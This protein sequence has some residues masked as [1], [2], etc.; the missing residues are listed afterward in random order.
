[1][2]HKPSPYRTFSS[3]LLSALF[4]TSL[5]AAGAVI[6]TFYAQNKAQDTQAKVSAKGEQTYTITTA[7]AESEPVATPDPLPAPPPVV[8]KAPVKKAQAQ[9]PAK[10]IVAIDMSGEATQE[11]EAVADAASATPV[12]T[13]EIVEAQEVVEVNESLNESAASEATEEISVTEI[14]AREEVAAEEAQVSAPAEDAAA[15]V[16]AEQA[17][18]AAT[19]PVTAATSESAPQNFV[20]LKQAPGNKPPSYPEALRM[21][22]VQGKGQLKYFVTKEGRVSNVELVQSTGSAELDQAA[23]DAFS[24]YKFVPGQ[25][26]YTVHNFEFTLQ[27]PVE[28]APRRLRTAGSK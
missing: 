12:V 10:K 22:Q 9:K 7:E 5:V 11:K 2:D 26:G 24:K 14:E 3:F 20:T 17:Q 27:G 28:K 6:G 25:E 8:A 19:A 18:V 1:M 4:H 15:E 21:K 16:A 23:L 13:E